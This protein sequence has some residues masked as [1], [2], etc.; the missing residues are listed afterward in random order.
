MTLIFDTFVYL[1][2]FNMINCRVTG[3]S[4][5]NVFSRFFCNWYQVF[6][7]AMIFGIQWSTN[8]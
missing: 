4:D 5:F 7:L 8:T 1:Q 2:F 3:D 6:I